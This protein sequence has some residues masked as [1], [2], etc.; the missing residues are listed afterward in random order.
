MIQGF[1]GFEDMLSKK[2]EDVFR[3]LSNYRGSF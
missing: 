3:I 1:K 2:V